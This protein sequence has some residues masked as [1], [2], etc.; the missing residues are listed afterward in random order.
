MDGANRGHFLSQSNLFPVSKAPMVRA[1]HWSIFT[2]PTNRRLAP[3]V[4]LS[5]HNVFILF[6]IITIIWG[7]DCWE[8]ENLFFGTCSRANMFTSLASKLLKGR[9]WKKRPERVQEGGTVK[10]TTAGLRYLGRLFTKRANFLHALHTHLS[11][12]WPTIRQKFN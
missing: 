9:R 6:S 8:I 5:T 3:H 1:S 11:F 12:Q 10:H 7:L 2:R 4:S